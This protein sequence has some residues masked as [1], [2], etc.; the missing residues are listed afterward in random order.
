MLVRARATAMRRERELAET[1]AVA[2]E[3]AG[4]D[5][6]VQIKLGRIKEIQAAGATGDRLSRKNRR[7][8]VRAMRRAL[9]DGSPAP[10][11]GH[12]ARKRGTRQ[13][14]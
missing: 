11:R 7:K 3:L 1:W 4:G 9:D 2:Y 13:D 10:E 5:P 12:K 14:G 8:A 6:G